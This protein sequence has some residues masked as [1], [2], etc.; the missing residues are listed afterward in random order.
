[1]TERQRLDN[2]FVQFKSVQK[3]SVL[4]VP[5][6]YIGLESHMGLLSRSNILSAFRYLYLLKFCFLR[7]L[8]TV[9]I[10]IWLSCP[11]RKVWEREMM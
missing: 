9:M 1:M 4:E 3:A 8:G 7:F 10:E 5:D 2:H 6:N 11:R